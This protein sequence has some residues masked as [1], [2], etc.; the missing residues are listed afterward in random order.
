MI[1]QSIQKSQQ[2][3]ETIRALAKHPHADLDEV[4]DLMAK[5]KTGIAA[6]E[7][8]KSLDLRISTKDIE[9]AEEFIENTQVGQTSPK[10][11]YETIKQ[12]L[13][14]QRELSRLRE[15]D[16]NLITQFLK[17][18]EVSFREANSI[19]TGKFL[20]GLGYL[21]S[22]GYNDYLDV[23]SEANWINIYKPQPIIE[24]RRFFRKTMVS[25]RPKNIGLLQFNNP[26]TAWN[27]EIYGR[28]YIPELVLAAKGMSK[29]FNH[30]IDTILVRD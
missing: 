4:G 27:L 13:Q 20:Q 19:K 24:T 6:L 22:A 9:L 25:A 12:I 3:L 1:E 5:L 8:L 23:L 30:A 18:S 29:V 26:P 11:S 21:V 7:G 14:Q 28:P 17:G 2:A 16:E 15:I 10:P